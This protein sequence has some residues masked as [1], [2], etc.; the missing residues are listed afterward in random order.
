MYMRNNKG[1]RMEPCGTP[2]DNERILEETPSMMA[3]ILFLGAI[4]DLTPSCI[5]LF[6]G[7]L[8]QFDWPNRDE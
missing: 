6:L 8:G 5:W 7:S 4:L 1:P 2:V 3:D